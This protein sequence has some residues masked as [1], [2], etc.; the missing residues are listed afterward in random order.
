MVVVGV[1]LGFWQPCFYVSTRNVMRV[2][3]SLS[4]AWSV[5]ESM[6]KE[7]A[8]TEKHNGNG[9]DETEER[10]KLLLGPSTT[11]ELLVCV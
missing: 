9:L 3:L 1:G 8:L 11:G 4:L 10:K 2:S 6:E 7:M 5:D